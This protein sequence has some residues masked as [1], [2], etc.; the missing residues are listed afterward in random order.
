MVG[1]FAF[2]VCRL[3][4]LEKGR[5]GQGERRGGW[6]CVPGFLILSFRFW[7]NNEGLGGC[8]MASVDVG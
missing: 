5:A 7:M 4:A 2:G 6:G 3:L 1:E 8:D